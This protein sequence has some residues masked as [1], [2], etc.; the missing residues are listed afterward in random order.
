MAKKDSKTEV[1]VAPEGK[2]TAPALSDDLLK[3]LAEHTK[4]DSA[5]QAPPIAPADDV[6][7]ALPAETK[8]AALP[9]VTT[10]AVDASDIAQET[11]APE[12]PLL[13]NAQTDQAV[14]EIVKQEGDA[15]L[16]V[17]DEKTAEL[18]PPRRGFWGTIG[19]FFAAWWGNKIARTITILVI[20][21]GIAVAA[22]FPQS[23]YFVLNTAGVRSSSSVKVIDSGTR[24]PLKNVTVIVG[25]EQAKTNSDGVARIKNVKL[26]KQQLTIKR[27]AFATVTQ[28]VTIGWGSNPLG[29]FLLR[30]TGVRYIVNVKDYISGKGIV[31]A[32]ATSG[33]EVAAIADKNGVVTLT[34]A[35]ADTTTIHVQV[36][37]KDYR[38]EEL[39]IPSDATVPANV[40]LVPSQK[41]LFVSKQSGRYDLMSMDLDGK[42]RKVILA[43]TGF[44]NNN[45]SMVVSPNGETVALVSTRDDMRDEDGYRLSTL[46]ILPREGETPI[47]VTHAEQIQLIDW[48]DNRL[49]YVEASAG[50]S[51]ANPQRYRLMSYD[52]S[53]NRRT[54]LATANQ[55]NG[56]VSMKGAIYYAVSS[57][58]P[59]IHAQ[60]YR[61]KPDGSNRQVVFSQEVWTVLRSSYDTVQLQTPGGWYTYKVDGTPQQAETPPV[62]VGRGYVHGPND[63]TLTIDN[64][65]GKGAILLSDANGNGKEMVIAAQNGLTYPVRWLNDHTVMYRVATAQE[66]ADYAVD[67][68]GGQPKRITDV[69]NTYGF[70][71]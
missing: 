17:E 63:K 31:G 28:P 49:I 62:L 55:F 10:D 16:A 48:S 12:D 33:D 21:V 2:G 22:V 61:V 59:G 18:P 34:F 35:T 69:S 9:A 7:A 40:V 3:Q 24:L 44:E 60:F 32:E 6:V 54:T 58:D 25:G 70:T 67:T 65:D 26:G 39:T 50:A 1:P 14:D 66:V 64:R 13:D 11:P 45:V 38:S 23:R 56:I 47:A 29:D 42:D 4:H 36:A 53:A 19:H 15:L 68:S 57:T 71:Y 52:Y 20:L 8:Q 51:A 37:A 27:I 41:A 5:E 46:T 30:P 43:G